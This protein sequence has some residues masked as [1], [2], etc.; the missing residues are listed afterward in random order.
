V[1]SERQVS[2]VI[3][4]HRNR[5]SFVGQGLYGGPY[6]GVLLVWAPH[7]REIRK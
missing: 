2:G 7:A 3:I 5:I 1:I 6:R 4:L